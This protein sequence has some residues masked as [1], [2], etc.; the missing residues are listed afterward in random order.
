MLLLR[1]S[2]LFLLRF[3]ERRLFGLLF[4]EPPRSTRWTQSG[5]SPLEYYLGKDALAQA[6]GISLFGVA[7]PALHGRMDVLPIQTRSSIKR[8]PCS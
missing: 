5:P 4:Q 3:A 8:A 6:L 7:Y 1:L 2:A